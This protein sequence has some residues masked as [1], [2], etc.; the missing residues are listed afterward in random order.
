M[1]SFGASVKSPMRS[2]MIECSRAQIKCQIFKKFYLMAITYQ[3]IW[4]DY[5]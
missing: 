3:F 2:A 4:D 1:E 5:F